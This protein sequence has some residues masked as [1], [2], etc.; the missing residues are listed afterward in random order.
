[1]IL[2]IIIFMSPLVVALLG[3]NKIKAIQVED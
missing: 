2:A 3:D 1:M